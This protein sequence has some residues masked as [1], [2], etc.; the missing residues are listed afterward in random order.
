MSLAKK[1]IKFQNSYIEMFL[2]VPALV[3][4]YLPFS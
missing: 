3:F 1:V 4:S 2:V